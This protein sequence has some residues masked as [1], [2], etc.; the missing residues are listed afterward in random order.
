MVEG[1]GCLD[2]VWT[3]FG[4]KMLFMDLMVMVCVRGGSIDGAELKGEGSEFGWFAVEDTVGDDGGCKSDTILG[5]SK[6][7]FETEGL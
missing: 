6:E 2:I 7:K 4:L 5:F 1:R 3:C